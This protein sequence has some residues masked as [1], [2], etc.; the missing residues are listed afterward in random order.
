VDS[1]PGWRRIRIIGFGHFAG[2]R[3]YV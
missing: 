1:N 2:K 3:T